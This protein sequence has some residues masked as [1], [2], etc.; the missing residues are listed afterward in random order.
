MGWQRP[1]AATRSRLRELEQEL[2]V[3]AR[4]AFAERELEG[5]PEAAGAMFRTAIAPGAP[6]A[7]AARIGM[8]GAI[9]L[10]RWTPFVATEVLAPHAGFVWTAR[11][12]A[13][14]GFDRYVAGVGEMHWKLLGVIPVMRASGPDV[15]RSAAGR[16]AAEAVWVPAA[17]LPRFGVE[18]AVEG[19]RRLVAVTRLDGHELRLR[20]ELD[21]AG[22]V[23]AASFH[24]WGDPDGTGTFGLHPF[25]MEATAW[26]TFGGVTVPSSGHAG[27]HHGTDRWPEGIFFRF[28]LTALELA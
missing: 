26:A 12:G 13:V 16:V 20:L 4:G 14:S 23:R 2:L 5:L 19:D 27:W 18:W 6:L 8:R 11:A 28:E 21:E 25:G 17:L 15:S 1:A 3:P 7:C 22:R 24:R 10:K 9:R